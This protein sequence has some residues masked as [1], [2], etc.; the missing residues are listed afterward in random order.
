MKNTVNS[1]EAPA[2]M[3]CRAVPIQTESDRQEKVISEALEIL[4]ARL[5]RPG[6]AI[7]SPGATRDYLRL[8]LAAE[9]SEQFCAIWLDNRNRTLAFDR[10][11][12]GTVDGASVYPREVV[13]AALEHNAAAVIF[14]HNHPSGVATPSRQDHAITSRLKD[15]LSLIGVRVLDHI[16]VGGDATLD[17]YSLAE[18]GEI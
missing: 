10:L 16:I 15:A 3:T 11:F 8:Q 6:A 7:T 13:R 4:A 17:S 2:Y 12:S 1:E 14:A 18:H 9:L 5:H